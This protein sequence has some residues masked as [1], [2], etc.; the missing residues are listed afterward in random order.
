MF[1]QH[2]KYLLFSLLLFFFMEDSKDRY[3]HCAW[4]GET[5][6][7]KMSSFLRESFDGFVGPVPFSAEY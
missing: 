2:L 3:T 1:L 6:F 4:A 5:L 7:A